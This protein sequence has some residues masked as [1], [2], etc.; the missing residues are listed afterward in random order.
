MRLPFLR[1]GAVGL[2][3]SRRAGGFDKTVSAHVIVRSTCHVPAKAASDPSKSCVLGPYGPG[4][5]RRVLACELGVELAPFMAQ[6]QDTSG[7]ERQGK[8]GYDEF[9]ERHGSRGSFFRYP[10]I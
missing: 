9:K 5:L 1:A 10:S 4:S 7:G 8:N 6:Q 3:A 2:A